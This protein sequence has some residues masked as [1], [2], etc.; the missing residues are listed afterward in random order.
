MIT[1]TENQLQ[2]IEG[3]FMIDT[4]GV[5]INITKLPTPVSEGEP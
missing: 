1:L 2:R 3:G 5:G 4:D